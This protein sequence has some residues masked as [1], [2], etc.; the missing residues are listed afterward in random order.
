MEPSPLPGV[1]T[2]AHRQAV[3]VDVGESDRLRGEEPFLHHLLQGRKRQTQHTT[4]HVYDQ[5]GSLKT[6]A[7]ILRIF[8]EHMQ[9]KYDRT[10]TTEDS[11]KRLLE[12]GLR[13]KP[14]SA[15]ASLEEHITMDELTYAVKQSKPNKAPGRDGICL[16]FY[17]IKWETTK[18]DLLD[19]INDMY[20]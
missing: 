16:E 19:I 7:D 6:T 17:K 13:A 8:A 18:Q 5:H 4:L 9:H 10:A 12:C 1:V 20:M 14:E 3:Q 11:M 15:N 2:S